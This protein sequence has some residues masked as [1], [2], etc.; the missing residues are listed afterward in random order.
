MLQNNRKTTRKMSFVQAKA[1]PPIKPTKQRDQR[2]EDMMKEIRESTSMSEVPLSM[3]IPNSAH[4]WYLCFANVSL[5]CSGKMGVS[6]QEALLLLRDMKTKYKTL[7][8]KTMEQAGAVQCGGNR[9]ERLSVFNAV[10][11]GATPGCWIQRVRN[12]GVELTDFPS[13]HL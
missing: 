5:F 6:R 13:K 9:A 7:Y 4:L 8:E 3:H 2:V 10:C 1:L 12:K 11:S